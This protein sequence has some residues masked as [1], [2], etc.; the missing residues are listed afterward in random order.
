[1]IEDTHRAQVM[2]SMPNEKAAEKRSRTRR[3]VGYS[4]LGALL[5]FGGLYAAIRFI[6]GGGGIDM[7]SVIL[8]GGIVAMGVL[9]VFYG[10]HLASRELSSAFWDDISVTVTK[11][12]R[13]NGNGGGS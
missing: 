4:V 13:R 6:D 2:E 3:G 12:W 11:V 1:M 8:I 5:A 9:I 7:W 10:G